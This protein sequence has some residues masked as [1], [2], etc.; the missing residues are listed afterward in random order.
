MAAPI[1]DKVIPTMVFV[2]GLMT[3]FILI[4]NW[5]APT[6][7]SNLNSQ[8]LPPGELQPTD[9]ET[10]IFVNG[11]YVVWSPD[12]LHMNYSITKGSFFSDNDPPTAVFGT[13]HSKY[14]HE[15][16]DITYWGIRNVYGNLYSVDKHQLRF[17]QHG[18]WLGVQKYSA[19]INLD[20]WDKEFN[21]TGAVPYWHATLNL[22]HSYLLSLTPT[23]GK[24]VWGSFMNW[25]FDLRLEHLVN[26]T[27]GEDPWTIAAQLFTFSLP[28]VPFFLQGLIMTPIWVAIGIAAYAIVRSV[29]P[30]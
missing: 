16:N 2:M 14:P 24:N 6:I 27:H 21:T 30:F 17:M 3:A 11:T 1:M 20:D 28:G 9:W 26:G 8:Y 10:T 4:V 19:T 12:P 25:T 5:M 18:G 15:A 23:S 29:F 22:R 13:D 7:S